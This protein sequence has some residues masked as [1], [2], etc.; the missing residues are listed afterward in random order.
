MELNFYPVLWIEKERKE[1]MHWCLVNFVK[2]VNANR[3]TIV[4]GQ[5]DVDV[6]KEGNMIMH[7][8]FQRVFYRFKLKYYYENI[9]ITCIQ[10]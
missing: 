7:Y 4:I 6:D 9:C 3:K 8:Y 2:V 5:K 10:Q 1:N